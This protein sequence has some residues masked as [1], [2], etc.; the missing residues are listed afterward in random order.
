MARGV[1]LKQFNEWLKENEKHTWSIRDMAGWKSGST[2]L[3]KYFDLGFDT[4]TMDIF[5]IACRGSCEDFAVHTSDDVHG[6]IKK[7]EDRPF[8]E[9]EGKDNTILDLLDY[10]IKGILNERT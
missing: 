4:R 2:H 5:R 1:K 7:D 8:K 10:K 9:L 3:I 6:D